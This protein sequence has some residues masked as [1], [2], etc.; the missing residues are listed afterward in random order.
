MRETLIKQ[1]LNLIQE[2]E[3][4]LRRH[5]ESA[6]SVR[7]GLIK[8]QNNFLQAFTL[9]LDDLKREGLQEMGIS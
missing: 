6:R 4:D 3:N 1:A 7:D 5:C 8:T 9:D 2:L